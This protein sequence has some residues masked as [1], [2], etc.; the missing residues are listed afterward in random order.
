MHEQQALTQGHANMVGELHWR[1]TRAAFLAIDDDE[2]RQ[3]PGFHH[4]LGDT[5][6]LP[7]MAQ[8]EL[9]AHRLAT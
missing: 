9:E 6:E 5:H 2:V 4:G 3:D 7:R 8:A 1:S